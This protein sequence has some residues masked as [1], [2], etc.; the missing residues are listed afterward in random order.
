M[1]KDRVKLGFLIIMIFS[2]YP[3]TIIS[4][5]YS[6]DSLILKIELHQL[7]SWAARIILKDVYFT[8]GIV[9]VDLYRDSDVNFLKSLN[10]LI[11]LGNSSYEFG[12]NQDEGLG[13]FRVEN[14]HTYLGNVVTKT[15]CTDAQGFEWNCEK[16]EIISFNHNIIRVTKIDPIDLTEIYLFLQIS[17]IFVVIF[18]IPVLLYMK[19]KT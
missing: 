5:G 8:N 19:F 12:D 10:E 15:T 3:S 17:L 6:T 1:K 16:E 7:G 13:L 14:I 18:A 9:I 4:T 2:F 11:D